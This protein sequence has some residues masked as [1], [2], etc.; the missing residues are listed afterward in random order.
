[1]RKRDKKD[2]RGRKKEE[3]EGEKSWRKIKEIESGRR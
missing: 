2:A 3:D 1:M